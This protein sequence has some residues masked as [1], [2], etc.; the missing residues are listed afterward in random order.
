MLKRR[1]HSFKDRLDLGSRHNGFG[2]DILEAIL[3]LVDLLKSA[4]M[5]LEETSAPDTLSLPVMREEPV[6]TLSFS[7]DLRIR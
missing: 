1:V 2:P 5:V 6:C 7:L 4:V 3:L